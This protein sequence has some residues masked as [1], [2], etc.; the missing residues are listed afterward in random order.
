MEE[1][2]EG[3]SAMGSH[4]RPSAAAPGTVQ[5]WKIDDIGQVTV[6]PAEPGAESLSVQKRIHYQKGGHAADF[7]PPAPASVREAQPACDCIAMALSGCGPMPQNCK[8]PRCQY[9]LSEPVA[10]GASEAE[11]RGVKGG[12]GCSQNAVNLFDK[13]KLEESGALLA[14]RLR[15]ACQGHP[16]AKIPWPHRLLHEA[17]DF[18]ENGMP[19]DMEEL[20]QLRIMRQETRPIKGAAL[21]SRF[22][23]FDDAAHPANIWWRKHGE[24]MLSGGGRREFIWACRGWI[25]REQL[26]EGV[27]VTGE[28]LHESRPENVALLASEVPQVECMHCAREI[29]KCDGMVA[30]CGCK[31]WFHRD[32]GKGPSHRCYDGC[33]TVAEPV[34]SSS[35]RIPPR[36]IQPPQFVQ[37][38]QTENPSC[39][40]CGK[41]MIKYW[42]DGALTK[43]HWRCESC[44]ATTKPTEPTGATGPTE[45]GK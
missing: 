43:S 37:T 9:Y 10:T 5:S 12:E 3:G 26:A 4:Y 19:T 8:N 21:A 7:K 40:V 28:S 35:E 11:E 14:S 41:P 33:T 42:S 36:P 27:E 20:E 39:Q 30:Y 1:G 44:G 38:P 34:P 31:G 15:A 25:A 13:Y 32:T 29:L 16:A 18:I 45:E 6:T 17:A 24:Y 2:A 23:D 22:H